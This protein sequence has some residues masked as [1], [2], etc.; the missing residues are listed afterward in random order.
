MAHIPEDRQKRGLVLDFSL[1]DN[2]IL[3]THAQPPFSKSG[4][5]QFDAIDANANR[6]IDAFDVRSGEGSRSKARGLSGGNQQKLIVGREIDH[7]PDVLIA[8]QPTRGL[9]VG[10]IEYIHKRLVE[11][12]DNGKAVLL[13]SLELDEILDL[14][15]WIAVV[16]RGELVGLVEASKTNEN[17]IGLLMAGVKQE[18]AQ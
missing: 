13:V 12:R 2:F 9:D 3:E 5:L 16:C 6:L 11:Q 10:S 17:E 7:N 14:S 1:A 18:R 4:F 8:V 15:D